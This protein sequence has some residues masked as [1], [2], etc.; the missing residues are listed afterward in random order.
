MLSPIIEFVEIDA[1][2][3]AGTD[4]MIGS[5]DRRFVHGQSRGKMCTIHVAV[6]SPR[7]GL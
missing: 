4:A 2:A 6:R 3:G 5:G 7:V 1:Q